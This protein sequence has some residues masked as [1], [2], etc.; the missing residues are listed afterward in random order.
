MIFASLTGKVRLKP[1]EACTF[2]RKALRFHVGPHGSRMA[3]SGSVSAEQP[4]A[5]PNEASTAM[6]VHPTAS[7]VVSL[8][9]VVSTRS[10]AERKRQREYQH[11]HRKKTKEEKAAAQNE[12]TVM[13]NERALMLQSLISA[14]PVAER[15]A[16]MES[17]S[18]LQMTQLVA[19]KLILSRGAG[20]SVTGACPCH[21][22]SRHLLPCLLN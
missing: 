16:G 12:L 19:G 3:D 2:L 7:G 1:Q 18:L 21:A 17:F 13:R 4:G 11:A 22:T 6:M 10:E 9:A 15:P 20:P 5:L 14:L 8:E